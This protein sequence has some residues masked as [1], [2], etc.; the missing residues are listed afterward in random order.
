LIKF[1]KLNYWKACY[2]CLMHHPPKE[3]RSP[4]YPGEEIRNCM[5][6]VS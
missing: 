4:C 1:E 2:G 3:F 6:P 5:S